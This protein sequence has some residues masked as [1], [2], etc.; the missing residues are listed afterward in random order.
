VT[1]CAR[2]FLIKRIN[3]SARHTYHAQTKVKK[4]VP[5]TYMLAPT[6]VVTPAASGWISLQK[7]ENATKTSRKLLNNHVTKCRGM[8]KW[9]NKNPLPKAWSHHSRYLPVHLVIASI[10]GCTYSPILFFCA[11]GGDWLPGDFSFLSSS[12]GS[13]SQR[14]P[15]S[16]DLI[17]CKT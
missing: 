8:W 5:Q 1:T 12:N 9:N 16:N 4:S 11:V 17:M 3:T 15:L 7:F 13:F 10:H 6:Q 2:L 14:K